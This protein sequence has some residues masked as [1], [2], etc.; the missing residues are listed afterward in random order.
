[1]NV[2]LVA[3]EDRLIFDPFEADRMSASERERESENNEGIVAT[4]S[5]IDFMFFA[6]YSIFFCFEQIIRSTMASNNSLTSLL[7]TSINILLILL[8]FINSVNGE[9][10]PSA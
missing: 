10:R 4:S 2:R 5:R 6:I 3:I 1:M 8:L 7:F 9:G